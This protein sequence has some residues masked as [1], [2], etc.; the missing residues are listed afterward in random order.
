MKKIVITGASGFIGQNLVTHFH[1]ENNIEV[2][3]L[4][5]RN[6]W[7][8]NKNADV[9]IHLAAKSSDSNGLADEKEYFKVNRD[10]TIDLF[11][12][13]LNSSIKDFIYFSSVK[14]IADISNEELD[15]KSPLNPTSIYGRS[16]QLAEEY[17]M[18]KELPE[19]KRLFIIR[20]SLV[21]GRGN[22]GNLILLYKLVKKGIP[23][24][25]AGFNNQRSFLSID[26]LIYCVN[27][28]LMDENIKS[29]IYNIAD[30]EPISVNDLILLMGEVSNRGSKLV[31]IP[32]VVISIMFK[33]GDILHFPVNSNVLNKLTGNYIV[34]NKKIK[35]ALNIDKL[36]LS[37]K[38]GLLKT[39]RSIDEDKQ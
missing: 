17:L 7:T 28:I 16:K 30:D 37:T 15:E 21:H 23:W 36:P 29:G 13:F 25:F 14:A 32:K 4:S 35:K 33:I 12:E 10:L 38:D 20:P 18:K 19:G 22:Q 2:E 34:S 31:S 9:V 5:L 8:L 39:L 24:F 3:T 11:N 6:S 26:N 27:Q 1:N